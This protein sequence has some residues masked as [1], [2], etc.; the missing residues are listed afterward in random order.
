MCRRCTLGWMMRRS[1][2]I[3]LFL[4]LFLITWPAVSQRSLLYFLSGRNKKTK[5]SFLLLFL[6][7]RLRPVI[8]C[9]CCREC[10]IIMPGVAWIS[11]SLYRSIDADKRQIYGRRRLYTIY[12]YSPYFMMAELPCQSAVFC[13]TAFDTQLSFLIPFRTAQQHTH[14]G[15]AV[16]AKPSTS[17]PTLTASYI[18]YS[19]LIGD[20][21]Q[22]LARTRWSVRGYFHCDIPSS[23]AVLSLFCKQ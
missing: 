6:S 16:A 2:F 11:L 15:D 18:I 8:C 5:K 22:Q 20:I 9:C 23:M 10:N 14:E 3:G 7:F 4:S 21:L 17:S 1:N 13:P 12:I 19:A